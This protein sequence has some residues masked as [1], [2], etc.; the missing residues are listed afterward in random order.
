MNRRI[1]FLIIATPIIWLVMIFPLVTLTSWWLSPTTPNPPGTLN[2]LA[3]SLLPAPFVTFGIFLSFQT[4]SIRRKWPITQLIGLCTVMMNVVIFSSP[5]L[6]FMEASKVAAIAS[7]AWV[8]LTVYA[9]WKAHHVQNTKLR[10]QSDKLRKSYRIMHL[11]DLH[12]GS[13]SKS[14][15]DRMVRQTIAQRPDIVFITGDLLDSSAVDS[16]YLKP[17]SQFR[18]PVYLCLGNHERYVN[19]T[20]AITAIKANNVK[21][22]RNEAEII[23]D[24]QI[25]GIDDEDNPNQVPN[26]L[27]EIM[28]DNSKYQILLYHR[29]TGFEYAAQAGIDLMLSGHTHNG[30]MWPF[31]ILVNRQFPYIKGTY[32]H[33]KATLFVSQGTGTWGPS[34]RLGTSSEMTLIEAVPHHQQT[35]KTSNK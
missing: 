29:P 9:I 22:L 19:L 27:P 12:A 34:M 35:E 13:R 30:Q 28:R 23:D 26:V 1:P 33:G 3:W 20:N 14:F 10:V 17:L 7:V 16:A 8:V 4:A 18:C 24:L 11:S 32:K 2:A 6:F 31:G 21:I 25:S 5:L 15:I